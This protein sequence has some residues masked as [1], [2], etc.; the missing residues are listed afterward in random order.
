MFLQ[1]VNPYMPPKESVS[2]DVLNTPEQVM[3]AKE[4]GLHE[5]ELGHLVVRK[6]SETIHREVLGAQ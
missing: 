3:R 5:A 4:S 1:R 6:I 2:V